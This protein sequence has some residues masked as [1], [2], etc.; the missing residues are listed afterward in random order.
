MAAF[1]G[2][3]LVR[4]GEREFRGAVIKVNERLGGRD[5]ERYQKEY[6]IQYKPEFDLSGC[7]PSIVHT[8]L[9]LSLRKWRAV[10]TASR[11][12]CTPDRH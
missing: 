7:C 1:A 2:D 3:V 12:G 8:L 5:A 10:V 9:Y 4:A 6:G 11:A